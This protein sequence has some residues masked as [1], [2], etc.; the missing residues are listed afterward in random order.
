MR[1][2]FH[3][4]DKQRDSET[5]TSDGEEKPFKTFKIVI[6]QSGSFAHR[7]LCW[8]IPWLCIEWSRSELSVPLFFALILSVQV[9]FLLF[10][11]WLH[12]SA[13]LVPIFELKLSCEFCISVLRAKHFLPSYFW[14]CENKTSLAK[15][16]HNDSVREYLRKFS[17]NKYYIRIMQIWIFKQNSV[18]RE[19]T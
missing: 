5:L 8:S 19:R 18:R 2:A 10:F 12:Q 13:R 1:G 16:I 11:F 4:K 14:C 3:E 15:Q 17:I 9:F 7:P 6:K